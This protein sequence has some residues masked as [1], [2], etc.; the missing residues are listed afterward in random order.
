VDL[1]EEHRWWK[2]SGAA[3]LHGLLL[4]CWDPVGVRGVEYAE[5]E[6]DGYRG[7][8]MERLRAGEGAEGVAAYLSWAQGR[9]GLPRPADALMDVAER[10]DAWYESL[11]ADDAGVSEVPVRGGADASTSTVADALTLI[12]PEFIKLGDGSRRWV[13]MK[14]F[15]V[16]DWATPRLALQMLLRHPQYCDDYLTP[17]SAERTTVGIHGPYELSHIT[18]GAF[19]PVDASAGRSVLS[20]FVEDIELSPETSARLAGAVYPAIERASHRWRLTNMADHEQH[21]YGSVLAKFEELVLLDES[22]RRLTLLVA[23]QD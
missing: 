11:K 1:K 6:Y 3:E 17:D 15:A 18:E 13:D 2:Q 8:V 9:L 5:N 7:G 19:E 23:G 12:G 20:M 22:G 16:P 4:D 14:S 21:E 10:I